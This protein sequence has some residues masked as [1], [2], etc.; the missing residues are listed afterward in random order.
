[1][2]AIKYKVLQIFKSIDYAYN[3]LSVYPNDIQ[4]MHGKSI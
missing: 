4:V 2:M 3:Y 1:M